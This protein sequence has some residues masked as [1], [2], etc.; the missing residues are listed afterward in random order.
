MA[1]CEHDALISTSTGR[2][3]PPRALVPRNMPQ[4]KTTQRSTQAHRDPCRGLGQDVRSSQTGSRSQEAVGGFP[5]TVCSSR[6]WGHPSNPS[7]G[8][9]LLLRST[10][11]GSRL[12]GAHRQEGV[13]HTAQDGGLQGAHSPTSSATGTLGLEATT[14]PTRC[15]GWLIIAGL[16]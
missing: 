13:P 3:T 15:V 16:T 10:S 7:A 1:S 11:S 9:S 2:S 5:A 8:I 12:P 14:W 4:K 6:M